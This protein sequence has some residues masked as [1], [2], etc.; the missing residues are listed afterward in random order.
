M[1]LHTE[2]TVGNS[3]PAD[4]PFVFDENMDDQLHEECG[5]FGIVTPQTEVAATILF[6]LYGLQ[7][8]GQDAAGIF[9]SDGTTFT[10]H[11]KR[12]LLAQVFNEHNLA[13][14]QGHL[15][16][17]HTRY[18]TSSG[19]K[20]RFVQP[21]HKG[22]LAFAF[23]GNLSNIAPL[24]KFLKEKELFKR[25]MNDTLMMSALLWHFLQETGDA[26]AALEKCWPFWIGAYSAVVLL[27]DTVIGVRGPE[28]IRPLVLGQMAGGFAMASESAA[29]NS[30][31]TLLGDVQPGH[32]VTLHTGGYK[33]Q[34]IAE[35]GLKSDVFEIIYFARPDSIIMGRSVYQMRLAMGRELAL[36][37]PIAADIVVPVPNTAI[38]FAEGYAE[39]LG[40]K[41]SSQILVRNNYIARTFIQPTQEQR[42]LSVKYKF[43][44]MPN[45]VKGKRI[46]LIDDSIVRGSTLA[47]LVEMLLR[48]GAAE[49]HVMSAAP[50]I[51]YP[52]FYGIA[53]PHQKDLIAAWSSPEEI[54]RKY[55]ATSVSFLSYRGMLHA[56]G[57]PES[58]LDTSCLTGVYPVDI[59]KNK[60]HIKRLSPTV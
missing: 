44:V 21:I 16:I 14:L 57:I 20:P 34:Q 52:N 29:F 53:T 43:N 59:G 23:N 36:E 55:G 5:V 19:N 56:I 45:E 13:D 17:G 60:R 24:I 1:A 4:V 7:H 30:V 38:P 41:M 51:R 47:P 46:V 27:Q 32:V 35:T 54:A 49:V 6:A 50:P 8:R 28:G 12:G 3:H 58:Q 33:D 22:E 25:G 2:G 39:V 26:T 15:G 31:G 18:T 40:L 11:K 42:N 48:A 37:H 10:G 9:T